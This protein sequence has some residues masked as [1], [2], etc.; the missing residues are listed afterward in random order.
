M[1]VSGIVRLKDG[2]SVLG[3]VRRFPIVH[4]RPAILSILLVGTPFFLMIPLFRF[5]RIGVGVFALSV[6]VG[7]ILALR[8]AVRWH[9]TVLIVTSRRLVDVEQQG[10]FDRLV[11]EVPFERIQD[12]SYA[13]RGFWGT[14]FGF[15]TVSVRI[16]A[17][18]RLEQHHIRRP[19]D[20]HHLIVEAVERADSGVREERAG[21]TGGGGK[22]A[23][24]G[25]RGDEIDGSA[26]ALGGDDDETGRFLADS[27]G[28][29]RNDV[30][31]R[32]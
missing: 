25:L 31:E 19:R 8:I 18:A 5:G 27:F 2:E 29:R 21:E 1:N 17:S 12:I 11:S 10:L 13:R 7:L 22:G 3:I 28:G 15:G 4:L 16:G 20:V 6:S 26:E 32:E 30:L 14:V 23:K 9:W 24:T